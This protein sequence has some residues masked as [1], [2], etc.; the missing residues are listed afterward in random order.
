MALKIPEPKFWYLGQYFFYLQ[1]TKRYVEITWGKKWE[2]MEA[3][4]VISDALRKD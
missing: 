2:F 3:T 1:E 4:V